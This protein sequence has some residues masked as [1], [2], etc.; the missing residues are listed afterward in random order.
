MIYD[1]IVLWDITGYNGIMFIFI[2]IYICNGIIS[3]GNP[4]YG[5]Y[6]GIMCIYI[7]MGYNGIIFIG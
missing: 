4:Y 5:I 2:Y 7:Y 6:I 1:I 3:L